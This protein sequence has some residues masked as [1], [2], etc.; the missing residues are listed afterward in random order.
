MKNHGLYQLF[1]EELEEAFDAERE[2]HRC[3]SGWAHQAS[4]AELKQFLHKHQKETD[5][6]V[7]R[8]D[9]VFSLLHIH[10][11]GKV[12][13]TM[14]GLLRES[15]DEKRESPGTLDAAIICSILKIKHYEMASYR[16]LIGLA[17]HLHLDAQVVDL[18]TTI[19]NEEKS[20]DA[21]LF[22]IIEG[23]NFESSDQVVNQ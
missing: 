5:T 19:W 3:I 7:K 20:A 14:R 11:E 4:S 22:K 18:L 8:L 10:A 6:Q 13:E 17:R 16:T 1:I 15:E 9:K 23:L 2:M 21:V 12:S